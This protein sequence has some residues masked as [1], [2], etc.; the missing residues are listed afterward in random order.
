MKDKLSRFDRVIM[1]VTF[2]EANEHNAAKRFSTDRGQTPE[3]K[4]HNKEC[5]VILANDL[6]GTEAQS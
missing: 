4:Q 1:A 5:G 6:L 3:R 2:A